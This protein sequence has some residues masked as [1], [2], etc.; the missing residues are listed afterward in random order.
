[1]QP[2][3]PGDARQL[4]ADRGGARVHHDGRRGRAAGA[5]PP[6]Q[7][8]AR[9]RT[10]PLCGNS[11][12]TDRAFLARDMPELDAFL[13]YRMVDVSSIKELCRRWYPAG[14]LLTAAEG[15]GPPRARRHQG[16][17]PGAALL[18]RARCSCRR[19]GP[20]SEQAQKAAA[21]GAVRRTRT[22]PATMDRLVRAAMVGV[23]QLVEHRVVV[24]GVAGS[25]PVTHPIGSTARSSPGRRCPCSSAAP[26]SP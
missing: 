6:A 20:T 15:P 23:A 24:P 7:A 1:M 17:H 26:A 25:S 4:R 10:V 18:P 5:R 16:E 19:P 8:R 21:R 11:I 12:A 13:H 3:V 9:A 2:V 22:E 14:L